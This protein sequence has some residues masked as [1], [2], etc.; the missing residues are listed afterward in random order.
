VICYDSRDRLW[1]QH[2]KSRRA[3]IRSLK[4]GSGHGVAVGRNVVKAQRDEIAAPQLAV[5][6]KIEQRQISFQL[7]LGA[8]SP[9]PVRL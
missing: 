1:R 6:G 4:S 8:G 5:D 7:R 2:R 3:A 9:L